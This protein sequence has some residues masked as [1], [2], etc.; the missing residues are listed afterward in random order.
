MSFATYQELLTH[1]QAVKPLGRLVRQG[2]VGMTLNLCTSFWDQYENGIVERA[3]F[4]SSPEEGYGVAWFTV[5]YFRTISGTLES[6][7]TLELPG[8]DK[9]YKIKVDGRWYWTTE[10][11]FQQLTVGKEVKVKAGG[12]LASRTSGYEY[13][14]YACVY[15]A[16][17]M[18][19]R[20]P[21]RPCPSE[22]AVRSAS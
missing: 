18:Q 8:P 4:R 14:A 6:K 22:H 21:W 20:R 11:G 7:G 9:E 1:I 5:T 10:E 12:P 16:P 19:L 2:Q 17:G 15:E 13:D 3:M